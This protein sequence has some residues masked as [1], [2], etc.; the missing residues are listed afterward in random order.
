MKIKALKITLAVFAV[1]AVLILIFLTYYL[2]VTSGVHLD[3]RKL[4]SLNS[5]IEIY[6]NSG[7]LL[8]E[9]SDGKSVIGAA[10][11]PEYTLNAFVAI[12]D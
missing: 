11:I 7:N 6:D 10:E 3:K 4:V 2:I 1:L 9:Q 5:S 12:E 8:D